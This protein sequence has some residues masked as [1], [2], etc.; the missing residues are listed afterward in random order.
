ME[1][2][3]FDELGWCDT[4]GAKITYGLLNETTDGKWVCAAR[5]A[6]SQGES[7]E[8]PLQGVAARSLTPSA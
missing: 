6:A 3:G 2:D 5:L 7:D 1:D 8:S 4:C